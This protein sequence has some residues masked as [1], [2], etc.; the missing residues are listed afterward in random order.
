[1]ESKDR[2]FV[3]TIRVAMFAEP[4]T[5]PYV[6]QRRMSRALLTAPLRGERA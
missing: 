2:L 3:S 6:H 1:M 4:P 5:V